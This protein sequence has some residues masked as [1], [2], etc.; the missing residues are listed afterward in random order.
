MDLRSSEES[1]EVV[2]IRMAGRVGSQSTMLTASSLFQGAAD[3]EGILA[4]YN[5][6]LKLRDTDESELSK[7]I[8]YGLKLR[9]GNR[10]KREGGSSF[11]S[12]FSSENVASLSEVKQ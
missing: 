8:S 7:A 4:I 12:Q 9:G 3:P 2:G 6:L 10:V 1:R 11:R 5:H